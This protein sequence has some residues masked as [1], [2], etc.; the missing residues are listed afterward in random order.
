MSPTGL[1]SLLI[2]VVAALFWAPSVNGQSIPAVGDDATLDV[3]T[4]NIEWFGN[5]SNAPGGNIATQ[6]SNVRKIIESSEIDVWGLQEI[7]NPALFEALLDSLGD[8]Y[9]GS[10]AT[11][12]QTQKIAFIY[13]TGVISPRRIQHIL[14][15]AD[16]VFGGRAPLRMDADVTLTDTTFSAHFITVH[17]KAGSDLAS[18][19]QRTE[20]SERF[21]AHLDVIYPT[22]NVIVL[23]DFNDELT[24]SIRPGRD[25]PYRNFLDDDRYRFITLESEERG[26][27]SFPG[28][29]GSYLDHILIT[30]ELDEPYVEDSAR[31]WR[32]LGQILV[33]YTSTTS[34]HFPVYARFDFRNGTSAA[35]LAGRFNRSLEAPYPNPSAGYVTFTYNLE[36]GGEVLLEVIDATGR[37]LVIVDEGYQAPGRHD[38]NW[39]T[40]HLAPGI[41]L[42]RLIVGSTAEAA[43]FAVVR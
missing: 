14:T 20:A 17:M 27:A 36:S 6:F 31:P 28:R 19:D 33:G 29:G 34:D 16:Q 12:S 2:A 24:T 5:E 42:L 38:V 18:Y 7:S 11:F 1:R 26:E 32:E 23:G 39:S 9:G 25:T 30:D 15:G 3:A 4:W 13:R 43:T 40:A 35:I 8:G 37:R 22:Q 10:L 21:K 41:Y